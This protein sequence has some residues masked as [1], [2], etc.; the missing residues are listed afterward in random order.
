MD[1]K[2]F[3]YENPFNIE[4]ERTWRSTPKVVFSSEKTWKDNV[5]DVRLEITCG[6][7]LYLVSRYDSVTWEF[8]SIEKE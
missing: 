1:E 3:G 8:L 2:W 7:A 6:E 4:Q 5:N